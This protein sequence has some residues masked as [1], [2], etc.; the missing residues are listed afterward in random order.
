MPS[1]SE[2]DAVKSFGF[3]RTA[4]ILFYCTDNHEIA[5]RQTNG[6][7][8]LACRS[9][10]RLIAQGLSLFCPLITRQGNY[11]K[12]PERFWKSPDT[13]I[14]IALTL[15]TWRA[16]MLSPRNGAVVLMVRTAQPI[17]GGHD[18]Q[19]ISRSRDRPQSPWAATFY[20]RIFC[21]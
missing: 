5:K 13:F 9:S 15:P 18:R 3:Y 12:S 4:I 1:V 10:R 14:A 21:G 8:P 11:T 17:N 6:I 20:P 19:D 7:L 16:R 2:S